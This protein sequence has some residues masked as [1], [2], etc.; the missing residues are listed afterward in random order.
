MEAHQIPAE[1]DPHGPFGPTSYSCYSKLSADQAKEMLQN[2]CQNH[3]D[4]AYDNLVKCENVCPG[5][6][7]CDTSPSSQRCAESD[8]DPDALALLDEICGLV[9]IYGQAGMFPDRTKCDSNFQTIFR[10]QRGTEKQAGAG[11]SGITCAVLPGSPNKC[12][13]NR[14]VSTP[15]GDIVYT[16]LN[17]TRDGICALAWSNE[18]ACTKLGNRLGVGIGSSFVPFCRWAGGTCVG[19]TQSLPS[20]IMLCKKPVIDCAEEPEGTYCL[21]PTAQYPDVSSKVVGRCDADSLCKPFW[22]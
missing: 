2:T 9:D 21:L 16:S 14:N 6:A 19:S 17:G 1:C 18:A 7:C 15:T 12:V 8:M 3:P 13:F 4:C 10:D 11:S 5:L 20:N 22:E